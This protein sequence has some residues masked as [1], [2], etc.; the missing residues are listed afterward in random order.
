MTGVRFL[1][2]APPYMVGEIAGFPDDQ[3]EKLIASGAAERYVA[4]DSGE[5]PSEAKATKSKQSTNA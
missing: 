3:A 4:K 1:H 2:N 5:T